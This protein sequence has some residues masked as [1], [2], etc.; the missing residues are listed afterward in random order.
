MQ[1]QVQEWARPSDWLSMPTNITSARPNFVGL[2][3]V[4]ENNDNYCAFLFT[5]STGQYKVDWGDGT[6][7]FHNSNTIAQKNYGYAS[8]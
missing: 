3:A 8:I 7:I 2:H 4:I 1:V 5:T 6:V